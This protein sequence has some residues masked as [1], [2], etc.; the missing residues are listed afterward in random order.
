[1]NLINSILKKPRLRKRS[2]LLKHDE[3][4]LQKEFYKKAVLSYPPRSVTIAISSACN[5]KCLFCAYHSHDASH[6]A[7]N[8]YNM[9][10]KLS[11]EKFKRMVDMCYEGR[12]PHV[13]IC[14][15]GEPFFHKE[16]L[17]MMDYMIDVYGTTSVQTN[18]DHA[19]FAKHSYLDKLIERKDNIAYI[20]TDILS[21]DEK[22]HE[23]MKK[24]SSYESVM[25]ALQYISSKSDVH[26]DVH[27]VLTKYNYKH[28]NKLIDDL[29]KREVNCHL[30]IVNL[31]PYQF[32]KVTTIDAVYLSTD[33]E[34]TDA[35]KQ[36]KEHGLSKGIK[37]T[38]PTPF[39]K[40]S[41]V[42]GAFWTRFQIWPVK[43]IDPKRYSENIIIGGCNAVVRGKLNTLGY[44]FDYKNIMDLWNNEYFIKTRKDLLKGLYPDKE[45]SFCQSYTKKYNG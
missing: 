24:G 32:N 27:Y 8:V 45:C 25:T 37:V 44:F 41:G 29:R 11:I 23:S 1:M 26:I 40:S 36:A 13:H 16:I 38:S 42:C 10:Y 30:A 6:G 20:T 7:S 22:E 14:A 5:N 18:F 19:V 15:T 39:D 4:S 21:G 17:N 34:I 43:G 12:V 31:H 9:P 3:A 35:L 28:I 33:T 2:K